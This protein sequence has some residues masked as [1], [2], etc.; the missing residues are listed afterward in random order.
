[1]INAMFPKPI[2]TKLLSPLIV[3]SPESFPK[4][5]T[6]LEYCTVSLKF[7]GMSN[8]KSRFINKK[9]WE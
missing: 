7:K 8:G 6:K 9:F 4:V 1:M 3:E 5:A 2:R